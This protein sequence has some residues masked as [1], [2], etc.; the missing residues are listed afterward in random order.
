MKKRNDNKK[1]IPKIKLKKIK[2]SIVSKQINRREPDLWK[3]I[4]L[5]FQPFIKA[6]NDYRKKRKIEKIVQSIKNQENTRVPGS[7]RMKNYKININS[8]VSIKEE[9]YNKIIYLNK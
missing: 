3:E 5:T 7:K 1:E 6:Y 4:G 9:L 8:E 2:N